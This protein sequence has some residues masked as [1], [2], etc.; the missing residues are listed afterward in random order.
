M[1]LELSRNIVSVRLHQG[2]GG[3]IPYLH[4]PG[5]VAEHVERRLEMH[6]QPGI[7]HI[8]DD[9]AEHGGVWHMAVCGPV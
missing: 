9:V 8:A 4:H 3:D 7:V 5:Y 1:Y 6:R 2:C